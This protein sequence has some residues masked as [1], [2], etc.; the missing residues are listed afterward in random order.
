MDQEEGD[1]FIITNYHVV[2]DGSSDSADGISE[3]INMYLYG[4]E[5]ENLAITT[6]YVG[7]SLYYDIAVLRVENSEV[8]KNSDACAVDVAD[9]D[10]V[11]VGDPAVV[12]GNAQ[13][14]GI[15]TT[16]GVISVDSEYITL[17]DI[18]GVTEV[19][20]RVMRTDAA[21]NGGNSGGG[22][23]DA[24]GDLIGVV[25]AK[26]VEE[27]VENIGYAIPSNI[28]VAVAQNIIDHCWE[29]NLKTVQRATLGVSVATLDSHAVYDSST[30]TV[31]IEETVVVYEVSAGSLAHG[32]LLAGDEL[33]SVTLNGETKTI[34]R[35]YHVIDLM[36]RARVGDTITFCVLRNGEACTVSVTVTVASMTAY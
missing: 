23:F 15:S 1:A 36:L 26:I 19:T 28:V 22:L 14:Y 24:N 11:F 3:S 2:Y 32:K 17:T 34:T 6:T 13:G 16:A 7:G 31:S 5:F 25:N 33:V 9:S 12:I 8:L 4:A 27:G 10:L 35:Q 29:T 21:V 18:D 20:L 30:G